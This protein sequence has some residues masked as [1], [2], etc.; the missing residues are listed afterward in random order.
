MILCH[1]KCTIPPG[2][3]GTGGRREKGGSPA[4]PCGAALAVVAQARPSVSGKTPFNGKAR[5]SP[6]LVPCSPVLGWA[7]RSENPH[8]RNRGRMRCRAPFL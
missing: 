1:E 7:G 8:F 5:L 4:C 6:G 3:S 2:F